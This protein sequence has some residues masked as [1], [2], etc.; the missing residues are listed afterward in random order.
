MVGPKLITPLWSYVILVAKRAK[1]VNWISSWIKVGN[2]LFY[3]L[4]IWEVLLK[5][6]KKFH[7]W[8]FSFKIYKCKHSQRFVLQILW[9]NK[10]C[11][12]VIILRQ[13]FH[14]KIWKF[15]GISCFHLWRM[16]HVNILLSTLW[17]HSLF[18]SF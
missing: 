7:F 2:S 11:C 1:L 13:I 3:I 17:K 12:E 4:R 6:F 9:Q 15:S 10:V 14:F 18:T 5:S 8:Q 16:F